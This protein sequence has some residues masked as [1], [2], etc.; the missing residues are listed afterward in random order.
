MATNSRVITAGLFA[1][2]VLKAI[3][4]LT[5]LNHNACSPGEEMQQALR[6]AKLHP[7]SCG[8]FG[9][10]LR[11]PGTDDVLKVC[12]SAQDGYPAYAMWAQRNPGPG[13]PE[14][15]YTQR[16]DD[17][18]FVC[19]MPSYEQLNSH[20][21]ERVDSLKYQGSLEEPASYLGQA[22]RRIRKELGTIAR[23]DMHMG[24]FMYC[25]KRGEYIVTD[26]FAELRVGRE[27]AEGMATGT[28]YVRQMKWQVELDFEAAPVPAPEQVPAPKKARAQRLTSRLIA[29]ARDAGIQMMDTI[30][31]DFNQLEARVLA[32]HMAMPQLQ[33]IPRL[34]KFR[35]LRDRINGPTFLDLAKPWVINKQDMKWPL[36]I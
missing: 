32:Q 14:I 9:T 6:K 5:D 24:N 19:A 36:L 1:E 12:A 28:T 7:L 11:I 35:G 16:I 31:V 10:V 27:K 17:D 20:D 29:E 26:P 25:P 21:K 22:V 33:Q 13:I 23:E 8:H 3:G 34:T 2:T 18:F 15:Y 30:P 4:H